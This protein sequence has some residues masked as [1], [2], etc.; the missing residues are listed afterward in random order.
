MGGRDK[1]SGPN[2][3]ELFG[4]DAGSRS[5]GKPGG[6]SRSARRYA[7]VLARSRQPGDAE[8]QAPP[9]ADLAALE[10]EL[11]NEFSWLLNLDSGREILSLG[12]LRLAW[13]R[14]A[15][16]AANRVNA[17]PDPAETYVSSEKDARRRTREPWEEKR[18]QAAF[19]LKALP[20]YIVVGDVTPLLSDDFGVGTTPIEGLG[21]QAMIQAIQSRSGSVHLRVNRDDIQITIY[22]GGSWLRVRDGRILFEAFFETTST[23]LLAIQQAYYSAIIEHSQ[24]Q[25]EEYVDEH[26]WLVRDILEQRIAKQR[27][28]AVALLLAEED[29]STEAAEL[30]GMVRERR[31]RAEHMRTTVAATMV[32]LAMVAAFFAIEGASDVFLALFPV[33]KA[34]NLVKGLTKRGKAAL[35][36]SK[37][38]KAELAQAMGES[39]A[40]FV[41]LA[42]RLWRAELRALETIV[43]T[44]NPPQ[45][46][47]LLLAQRARGHADLHWVAK[48]LD[49][50]TFDGA[51]LGHFMRYDANPTWNQLRGLVDNSLDSAS[52]ASAASKLLGFL[53]EEAGA[54]HVQSEAFSRRYLKRREPIAV[55]RGEKTLDLMVT[56]NEGRMLFGE[57]K[58]WSVETWRNPSQQE[59]LSEQLKEH[60]KTIDEVA[61]TAENR[62]VVGKVLLV[63]ERGF[64]KLAEIDRD[65]IESAVNRLGW[66]IEIIPGERLE[67][68]GQFIDRMRR[69]S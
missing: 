35:R 25:F 15:M 4:P 17:L 40:Q 56:D 32:P 63:T 55:T 19:A 10:A 41:R 58:N 36:L 52:R 2:D 39:E 27:Q 62:E 9:G 65:R 11:V 31:E 8:M 33:G 51:F 44:V 20:E 60:N 50:G 34:A 46:I 69:G 59:K 49:D 3:Q 21:R 24:A 47:N 1:R 6:S 23:E 54:R 53:G 67:S 12:A 30:R 48:Q 16:E 37:T 13:A 57:T 68:M 64:T 26:P 45:V 22:L 18:T 14:Y 42:G 66:A 28:A 38:R 5:K 61:K 43:E 7:N 29:P